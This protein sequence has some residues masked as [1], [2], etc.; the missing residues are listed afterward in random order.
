VQ[1]FAKKR[2][3]RQRFSDEMEIT[4]PWEVFMALIEPVYHKCLFCP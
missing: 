3:R 2:S 1:I 4:I